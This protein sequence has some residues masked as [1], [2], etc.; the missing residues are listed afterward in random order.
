MSLGALGVLVATVPTEL[1][2]EAVG[3]RAVFFGLAAIT[4]AVAALIFIAVP[5]Q[6]G[7]PIG[8]GRRADQPR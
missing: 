1:A 4:F 2:V 8:E 3:W 5:E 7:H 6:G